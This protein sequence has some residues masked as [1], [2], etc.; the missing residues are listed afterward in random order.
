LGQHELFIWN[1]ELDAICDAIT[2][3]EDVRVVLRRLHG[4]LTRSPPEVSAALALEMR[5]DELEAWLGVA[6]FREV[7]VALLGRAAYMISRS[8]DGIVKATIAAG[9]VIREAVAEGE[10]EE[11]A[12]CAAIAGGLTDW[13]QRSLPRPSIARF[14]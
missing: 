7:A 8:G 5:P 2:A 12:I 1:G 6:A 10:S 9:D 3:G 14:S 11:Q 4:L 13:S